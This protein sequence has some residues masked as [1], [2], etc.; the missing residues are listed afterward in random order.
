MSAS[1]GACGGRVARSLR[2][3]RI[4]A[5]GGRDSPQAAP[6]T[7]AGREALGTGEGPGPGSGRP[8]FPLLCSGLFCVKCAPP[9]QSAVAELPGWEP[10]WL[11]PCHSGRSHPRPEQVGRELPTPLAG[12]LAG[13]QHR[14]RGG[15]SPASGTPSSRA[16]ETAARTRGRRWPRSDHAPGDALA[17]EASICRV[18]APAAWAMKGDAHSPEPGVPCGANAPNFKTP[19]V[20]FFVKVPY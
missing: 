2:A 10:T 11:R 20:T 12:S 13:A 19:I 5:G 4:G 1:S 17:L 6:G 3:L 15:R 9:C 18:F 8:N 14:P 16:G 7:P